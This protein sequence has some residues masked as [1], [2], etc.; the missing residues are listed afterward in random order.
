MFN[1]PKSI[2]LT[3]ENENWRHCP[4]C[5]LALT[6]EVLSLRHHSTLDGFNTGTVTIRCSNHLCGK[7][8][9][10]HGCDSFNYRLVAGVSRG[11]EVAKACNRIRGACCPRPRRRKTATC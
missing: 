3:P 11:S 7:P 8:I 9:D 10:V 6:K 5:Q 4:H 1:Q 2:T